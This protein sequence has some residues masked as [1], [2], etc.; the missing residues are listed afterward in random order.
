MQTLI[1]ILSVIIGIV[2]VLMLFSLLAST[3]MEILAALL[4]LRGLHLL[5]TL[6]NMLGDQTSK[7][8]EHPFF[9]Q[10]AYATGRKTPMTAYSLPAW[11]NKSTFS[12]ILTDLLESNS[13]GELEQKIH[14]LPDGDLKELLL[15]LYR[16]TDGTIRQFK[17]KVENWFDEVMERAS[18]WYKRSTKWWLFGVGFVMA[19]IFNTDTIQIY[20]SLSTNSVLRE[21]FVTL[22]TTF[23]E[24][25]DSIPTFDANQ[26]KALEVVVPQFEAMA[27]T[28]KESVA[29]PLGLGWNESQFKLTTTQ[30]LVKLLGWLLS[31]IA[32]TFGAP[33]W[34]EIL[35]K[36][37]SI[38]S[39]AGGGGSGSST[40]VVNTSGGT[41][42]PV[43]NQHADTV[44][45]EKAKAP[46]KD[47][48]SAKDQEG[49]G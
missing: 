5:R 45:F 35:K 17:D 10:L 6:K 23:I 24:K 19:I 46:A 44:M 34:F 14:A 38:K 1:T 15:Y 27:K 30:W 37:I 33:F 9:R 4:S 25:N 13:G 22:A 29:S 21:D 16:Q 18:D 40:V 26:A 2:F 49:F 39:G 47:D 32:V 7:F 43:N 20:T 3:V 42:I 11:I 8:L 48:K 28:Y 41:T 12:A 36:L 31:G